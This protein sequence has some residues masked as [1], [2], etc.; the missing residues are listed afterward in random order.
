MSRSGPTKLETNKTIA[1]IAKHGKA[2]KQ[3]I[4]LVIAEEIGR[5]RR[6]RVAVNLGKLSKLATANAKK[7]LVVPGKVL[8][9]GEAVQGIQVAAFQYSAEAKAKILA[10]KGKAISLNELI[11]SKAKP[12]EMVLV[13]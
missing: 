11:D 13:K 3:K 6:Q 7:I 12:S 4:F 9:L 8:S 5:S 2:A 1:K 10:A